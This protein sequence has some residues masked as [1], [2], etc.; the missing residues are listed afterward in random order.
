M[1]KR[2][3]ASFATTLTA[4]VAALFI[5]VITADRSQAQPADMT[6]RIKEL[7]TNMGLFPSD[8]AAAYCELTLA[9]T[10]RVAA[11][12]GIPVGQ[13]PLSKPH[14]ISGPDSFFRSPVPEQHQRETD[15]CIGLG[16]PQDP[17]I[18]E[19][20][21]SSLDLTLFHYTEVGTD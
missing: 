8:A 11:S 21:V 18:L 13:G 4:V 17:A 6:G 15:A 14:D 5:V 9:D 12:S 1:P 3:F 20:C 2:C 16:L 7:C 19:Q 10:A